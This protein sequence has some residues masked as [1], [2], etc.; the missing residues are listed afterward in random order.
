[1]S[2]TT[3]YARSSRRGAGRPNRAGFTLMEIL[4]VMVI[5]GILAGMISTAA[6]Y[7]R[8]A[9]MEGLI[10]K[11]LGDLHQAIEAYK[12]EMGEYPPDGTDPAAV[13]RH[14]RKAFHYT[15]PAPDLEP[16]KA[17]V[18]WLGG[19]INEDGVP[20]GF[21]DSRT[22]PFDNTNTNRIGPFYEFDPTR[23]VPSPNSPGGEYLS[24]GFGAGDDV[25]SFVYFRAEKATGYAGKQSCCGTKPYMSTDPKTAGEW[26][27]P[28]SFQIHSPGLDGI[29]GGGTQYPSGEDYQEV[30]YDDQTNF[31]GGTLKNKLP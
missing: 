6:Y 26:V 12:A 29:H 22:T 30:D 15:G 21:S 8:V 4:T 20:M 11:E 18:F 10:N 16:C 5:I 13:K 2:V 28:D 23:I 19:V 1:M 3:D 14:L 9:T 25:D 17:L 27:N 7:A 31:S 24:N